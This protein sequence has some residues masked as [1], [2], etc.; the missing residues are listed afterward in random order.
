M[1]SFMETA[2]E[3]IVRSPADL[4][5]ACRDAQP[6]DV[7]LVYARSYPGVRPATL[8]SVQAN[9]FAEL[10]RQKR[11][12]RHGRV[13]TRPIFINGPAGN[14]A[15]ATGSEACGTGATAARSRTTG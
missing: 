10:R 4:L 11:P 1:L 9:F 3:R 5:A 15:L 8:K 7:I 12:E 14:F 6:G 13:A 2:L